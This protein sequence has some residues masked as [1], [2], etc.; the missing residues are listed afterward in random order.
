MIVYLFIFQLQRYYF[1][2][3]YARKC[4][5]VD[6]NMLDKKQTIYFGGEI[7]NILQLTGNILQK[8]G[9]IS[10][11]MTEYQSITKKNIR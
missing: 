3:T 8:D 6:K 9:S 7:F 1:F 2:L 4:E 11:V 10:K 5:K